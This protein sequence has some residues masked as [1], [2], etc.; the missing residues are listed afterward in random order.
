M[1]CRS[2]QQV[3]AAPGAIKLIGQDWRD[4]FPAQDLC[5]HGQL[6]D[7]TEGSFSSIGPAVTAKAAPSGGAAVLDVGPLSPDWH[8]A[9]A[10]HRKRVADEDEAEKRSTELAAFIDSGAWDPRH[11]LSAASLL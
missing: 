6:E 3:E 7:R 11:S 2:R 1:L 9:A 5:L 4:N 10:F 8:L